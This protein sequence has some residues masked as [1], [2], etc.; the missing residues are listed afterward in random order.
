MPL[1]CI[2]HTRPL[3]SIYLKNIHELHC[4]YSETYLEKIISQNPSRERNMVL[5]IMVTMAVK[6][7]VMPHL[8]ISTAV[9]CHVDFEATVIVCHTD[10]PR[11]QSSVLVSFPLF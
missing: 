1:K 6:C 10:W 8:I 4:S 7:P 5:A 11:I 9:F 3:T 2:P